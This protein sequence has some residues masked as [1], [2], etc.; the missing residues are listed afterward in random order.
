MNVLVIEDNP[1][2]FKL[3]SVVLAEAG[4]TV[5]RAE[6]AEQAFEEVQRLR[7]EVILADLALPG[8]DGL[9][10]VRT[11]KKNQT[12]REIPIVVI[13]AFP[14]MWSRQDAMAA[15]CDAYLLKPLDTRKL[16]SEI[17]AVS[18]GGSHPGN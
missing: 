1:S 7:P 15:G 16:V 18:R 11:L 14:D 2:H 12:T 10:L 13:T 5:S 17:A 3:V 4:N 9:A 8:M 6:N